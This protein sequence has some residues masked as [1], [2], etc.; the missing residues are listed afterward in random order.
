MSI[1]LSFPEYFVFFLYRYICNDIRY[2]KKKKEKK[3]ENRIVICQQQYNQNKLI[4]GGTSCCTTWQTNPT[5]AVIN[6]STGNYHP[7]IVLQTYNC[8]KANN[9]SLQHWELTDDGLHKLRVIVDV[10]QI[11]STQGIGQRFFIGSKVVVNLNTKQP[12]YSNCAIQQ[13][14]P[15]CFFIITG[16]CLRRCSDTAN[17]SI[18]PQPNNDSGDYLPTTEL[19]HKDNIFCKHFMSVCLE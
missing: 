16:M 8:K 5:P 4:S 12:Q 13:E 7:E 15:T 14:T 9:I 1:F 17:W 10:K 6:T 19:S 11:S 2:E 18:S 3:E